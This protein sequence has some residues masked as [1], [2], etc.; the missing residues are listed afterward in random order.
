MN[1][2]RRL[3]K[4]SPICFGARSK[5][6]FKGPDINFVGGWEEGGGW[7]DGFCGVIK[8]SR[9]ILMG[10]EIFFKIFDRPQNIFLCS[11][12]VIFF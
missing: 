8:Y 6:P 1:T 2:K 4:T 11:I 9:H 10:H 3:V 12:I 7:Q 5:L